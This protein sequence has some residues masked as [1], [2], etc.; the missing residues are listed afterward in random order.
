MYRIAVCLLVFIFVTGCVAWRS[1][2]DQNALRFDDMVE[3]PSTPKRLLLTLS[4]RHEDVSTYVIRAREINLLKAAKKV[5]EE[6]PQISEVGVDLEDPDLELVINI[7]ETNHSSQGMVWL[8][9]FTLFVIPIPNRTEYVGEG[10][11]YDSSGNL[12]MD[13]QVSETL[14]SL[15]SILMVPLIPSVFVVPNRIDQDIFK[16]VLVQMND[17]AEIL[18]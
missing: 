13:V 9:G 15:I 1:A 5:F 6:S 18:N 2:I 12:L 16:S 17:D 10:Q 7:N 14:R 4:V 8:S 3:R 11:I